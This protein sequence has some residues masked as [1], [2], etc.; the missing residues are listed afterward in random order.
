MPGN[1]W[2]HARLKDYVHA[3]GLRQS[4]LTRVSKLRLADERTASGSTSAESYE[5]VI[6]GF[7]LFGDVRRVA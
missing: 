6:D 7:A 2:K 5:N 4:L 3:R 1:D